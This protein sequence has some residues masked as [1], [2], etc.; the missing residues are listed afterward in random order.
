MPKTTVE[1]ELRT[2]FTPFGAIELV[3]VLRDRT[4]GESRAGGFVRFSD[5]TAGINAIEAL[6]GKCLLEV[7][8]K[9][10]DDFQ[11]HSEAFKIINQ[12]KNAL[13]ISPQRKPS[14]FFCAKCIT[15]RIR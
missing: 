1:D 5:R 6:H 13:P 2:L 11:I 10:M 4:T 15:N 8:L 12:S 7:V 14:F 9:L 3:H